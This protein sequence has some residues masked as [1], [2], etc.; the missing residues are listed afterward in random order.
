M[1]ALA[2]LI[3]SLIQAAPGAI[4]EITALYGTLKGVISP[5]D[6]SAIDAA[7]VAAQS[8]DAQA[9]AAADAALAQAA[10]N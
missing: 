1:I 7:L 6:Q 9:T 8:S 3:L 10:Q 5:K 2:P 4:N